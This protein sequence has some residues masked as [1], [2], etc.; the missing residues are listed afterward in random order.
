MEEKVCGLWSNTF[1]LVCNLG[2]PTHSSSACHRS[3]T[4]IHYSSLL[5]KRIILTTRKQAQQRKYTTA[6]W[7]TIPRSATLTS[8]F[9]APP[10]RVLQLA[11]R[12]SLH[13]SHL[14]SFSLTSFIDPGLSYCAT[15]AV[16]ENTLI[17]LLNH[18]QRQRQR[19]IQYRFQ[20]HHHHHVA[21]DVCDFLAVVLARFAEP[22]CGVG[23]RETVVADAPGE[24]FRLQP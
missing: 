23:I 19:H 17:K 14:F 18:H 21:I 3:R 11:R 5:T 12:S 1:Y 7:K 13:D 24:S 6:T 16:L 15:I 4:G 8:P 10:L 20:Y 2:F 9:S 22:G